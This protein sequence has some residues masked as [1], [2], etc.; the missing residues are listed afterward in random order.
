MVEVKVRKHIAINKEGTGDVTYRMRF[1]NQSDQVEAL[2]PLKQ[3][4]DSPDIV[5]IQV[6]DGKGK[7]IP[8]DRWIEKDFVCF[9]IKDLGKTTLEPGETYSLTIKF[10]MPSMA[11][12]FN[13]TYF[14]RNMEVWGSPVA[15]ATE[16]T[17]THELPKLFSRYNFWKEVYVAAQ[18]ASRIYTQDGIKMIEYQFVLPKESHR[19]VSF[20]FQERYNS[21]VVGLLSFL[22]G[23]ALIQLAEWIVSSTSSF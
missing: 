16:W 18:Q 11:R 12:R 10:T 14:F 2:Q 15:E 8:Y 7:S 13:K 20:M 9:G 17:V 5:N 6:S 4:I 3:T 21:K 19:E 23:V 22:L 1:T